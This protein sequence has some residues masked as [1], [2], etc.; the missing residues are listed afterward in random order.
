MQLVTPTQRPRLTRAA[1]TRFPSSVD[2]T[3]LKSGLDRWANGAPVADGRADH[4]ATVLQDGRVLVAGGYLPSPFQALVSSEIFD[5]VSNTWTTTNNRMEVPRAKHSA[6]L[7]PDGNVLVAGGEF[8]SGG[9]VG[10]RRWNRV[11][12]GECPAASELGCGA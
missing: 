6:V 7:L 8:A 3:T 2:A 1:L 12:R 5:P 4:T 10:D 9:C 11:V